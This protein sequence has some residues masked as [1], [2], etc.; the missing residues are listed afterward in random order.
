MILTSVF[1]LL[2]AS[3]QQKSS[4]IHTTTEWSFET[5]PLEV[6]RYRVFLHFWEMGYFLTSGGKFGGDF[7]IYPGNDV[8]CNCS[9]SDIIHRAG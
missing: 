1:L 8:V 5:N 6:L 2:L 3:C 9:E 4:E 7:L